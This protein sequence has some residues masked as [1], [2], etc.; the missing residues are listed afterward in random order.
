MILVDEAGMAS[1]HDLDRLTY[2][3][4][5]HGAVVRLLG[6]P[7][8]LAAVDTGGALRLVARS[9]AAPELVDVHRFR[10][11]EEA[12]ISLRLRDGDTS[13]AAWYAAKAALK[14]MASTMAPRGGSGQRQSISTE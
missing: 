12:E 8:Q 9:S 2:I 10:D 1:T 3:A 14:V 6:D 4:A 11:K 13:V 5:E 7:Q